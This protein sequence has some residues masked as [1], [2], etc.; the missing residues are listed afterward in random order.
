MFPSSGRG[1]RDTN[2]GEVTI[3]IIINIVSIQDR[4]TGS[5]V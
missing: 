4:V 1:I 5:N 3:T 2:M